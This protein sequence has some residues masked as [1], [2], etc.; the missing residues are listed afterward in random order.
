MSNSSLIQHSSG[1]CVYTVLIGG[2]EQLNEQP[3]AVQSGIPFICLT[4]DADLRS[5][6]WTIRLVR[7]TFPMDPIRSQRDLKI[8]PYV[9]LKE[10]Q[11]SLYIDNTVLLTVTPETVF[12]KYAPTTGLSLPSHSFRD[13]IVDEFLAVVE[14]GL[15]DQGR[16]FEQLNHYQA[17]CPEVLQEHPFW[18]AIMIREHFGEKVMAAMD[19]W[20]A[21]VLRYSRRDQLSFNTALRE[22]QLVPNT[23][24]IDNLKS[25]FHIWPVANGR[26]R[27][28]GVR[29]PLRAFAPP[30]AQVSLLKQE[31]GELRKL[32]KELRAELV[33][34]EAVHQRAIQM[35][36]A[37]TKGGGLS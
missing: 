16:V 21:H 20:S 32:E 27:N 10:F 17:Y 8:R 25:E 4:D 22:A 23:I 2:Y 36:I 7:P 9:H 24:A 12:E 5:D 1:R 34:R 3:M 31:L 14:A 11:S 19:M 37:R 13:T 6:T 30:I 35:G 28:R 26:D 33:E 15:D 18:T 29:A